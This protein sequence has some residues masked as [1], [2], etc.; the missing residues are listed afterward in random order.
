[1]SRPLSVALVGYGVDGRA[2]HAP[3]IGAT[4]GLRLVSVVTPNPACA[5]QVRHDLPT[6]DVISDIS[7]LW[8]DADEYDLL[9][10]SAVG[11]ASALP[12]AALEHG[13]HVVVQQ[14]LAHCAAAA[15]SLA[16][17]ARQH[18]RQLHVFHIRRWDSD[19]RTIRALCEDGVLGRV[20]RLDSRLERWQP[21]STAEWHPF[22]DPVLASGLLD[23]LA[24]DLVDQALQLLGPA[25]A[26]YAEIASRRARGAPD[27]VFV[28]LTHH[29][30][31]VSHL[32][33]ST[34]AA[35][36]GP[37]FRVLGSRAAYVVDG[38]DDCEGRRP[39]EERSDVSGA[40]WEP[41]QSGRL[42]PSDESVR[43]LPGQWPDF[44]RDVAASLRGT[45]HPPVALDSAIATVR[46]VDAAR[47]SAAERTVVR[48]ADR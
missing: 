35:H 43:S 33:V 45:G 9:V 47:A 6:V 7:A 15:E 12:H 1:M 36:P 18:H 29:S 28:A 37:R 27:D 3:L 24:A 46:V 13:L 30:G 34:L 39:S 22:R 48:L 20:H 11:A 26:V 40:A 32:W 23:D 42:L 10:V 14:P 31:A 44:Y 8:H 4:P 21:E 16:G 17:C 19:F 38:L 25:D 2:V 5:A 41:R